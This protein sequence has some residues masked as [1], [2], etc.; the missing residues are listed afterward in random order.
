MFDGAPDTLP[1]GAPGTGS[2]GATGDARPPG[3]DGG[4]GDASF[5]GSFFDGSFLDAACTSTTA[6]GPRRGTSATETGTGSSWTELVNALTPGAGEAFS[7]LSAPN[8]PTRSLVVTGFGFTVPLSAKIAGVTVR[9]ERY[10]SVIQ[11]TDSVVTLRLAGGPV[12]A[13]RAETA[14]GWPTA[15][16]PRDYGGSDDTWGASLSGVTVSAPSFGVS[17]SA[18]Y[19]MAVGGPAVFVDDVQMTLHVCD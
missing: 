1:D 7:A 5:D 2:D 10:A 16:A 3:S 9:I 18:V 4:A 8:V 17:V 14:T 15:L 6:V 13:S 19:P 11:I 12:G